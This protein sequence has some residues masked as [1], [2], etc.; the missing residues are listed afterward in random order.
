MTDPL[1]PFDPSVKNL[2]LFFGRQTEIAWLIEQWARDQDVVAV[3]GPRRIGK[4]ALLHA[5]TDRLPREYLPIYLDADKPV[6]WDSASPLLQ[7][8][9]EIGRKVREQAEVHVS[10]PDAA[11]FAEDPLLAWQSYVGGLDGRLPARRLVLLV[12]NAECAA[13]EWLHILLETPV[14]KVV[15]AESRECLS[16]RLSGTTFA[17][18]S[19]TL[20]PLGNDAAEDLVRALVTPKSPIDPWAVRR[21]LEMASNQPYY[22]HLVCR[23]LL[24]CCTL[25]SPITPPQVEAAL[26]SILDMPIAEFIVEWESSLPRE[27]VVLSA[28]AALRGVRGVAT[29]YDIQKALGRDGQ[30]PPLNDIVVNLNNLA[31]RGLLERMGS[32]SYRFRLEL[33]RLWVQHHYPLAEIVRKNAWRLRRSVFG[34]LAATLQ[35]AFAQRRTLWLSVA[36]AAI[37]VL[38]VIV[39]PTLWRRRP[40]PTSTPRLTTPTSVPSP[41]SVPVSANVTKVVPQPTALLPG[42]DLLMMSRVDPQSPWQIYALNSRTGKRLPI[43]E[44]TSNER[45]PKWSPDGRRIAFASDRD[46][47]RD[48]YVMD[49]DGLMEGSAD[50]RLS[51]L[52]QNETPDWQPAWSPDGKR[53]A[54]SSYQDDNWEI[55]VID[56]DGSNLTRVT[57]HPENDI[58]PTW[59]PDGSKLLFVS[60]RLGDADLFVYDLGTGELAQ[61]T[62]SELD[63]FDPA[64]SP[65]GEWIAFVTQIGA[66]SDVFVMRAD[67][68]DAAN[69]TQSTYANDFQPVWT[70]ASTQ[71]V[72]VSYTAAKG[73]HDLFIMQRDGS[74]VRPITSDQNDNIAPSLRYEY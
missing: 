48:I 4:T 54:F 58:S 70:A 14:P 1:Y 42:Y 3:Y 37:V 24:A 33:F 46:G 67:G 53:I 51:N 49:L 68:S 74:Q 8:A 12:D 71:L 25:K 64:W 31:R 52:T 18:P 44:T 38:L 32:N 50:T 55:S 28:F 21:L 47:D 63:E 34:G 29:Q 41:T 15:A 27:Q 2:Y 59:S 40:Q 57:N 66:Q 23:V 72:F 16:E 30:A 13:T 43:T 60:R 10:S 35:R 6:G 62:T 5:L 22:I 45:T 39:Q 61:L 9:G 17:P 73:E 65:D 7:I 56:V 19:I 26:E 11:R 36:V 69:L 20:G